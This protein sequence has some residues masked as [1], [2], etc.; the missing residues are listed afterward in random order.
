MLL[1]P[2]VKVQLEKELPDIQSIEVLQSFRFGYWYIIKVETHISDQGYLFYNNDPAQ[3]PYLTIWGGAVPA[4]DEEYRFIVKS[5]SKGKTR[6]IP[7][8]LARC[9]AWH[10]TKEP[11][12]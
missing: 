12:Q 10:M 11:S 2:I 4:T 5:L 1:A 6:G 3:T 8:A 9:F 7:K